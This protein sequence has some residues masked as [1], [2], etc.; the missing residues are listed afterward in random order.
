[1]EQVFVDLR[2]NPIPAH[3]A[4]ADPLYP[5]AVPE[6]LQGIHSI[7]DYLST[8][9][10]AN[11]HLIILGAPGSGKTT[12]LKHVALTLA[13]PRKYLRR[14]QMHHTF[15]ILLFLRDHAQAVTERPDFSLAQ[16]V[17]EHMQRTWQQNVPAT[18]I[19]QLLEKGRCLILL[20][21]L[22]EVADV[23]IRKQ[24]VAWVQR[25]LIAYGH[26][27]F[28]VTSRPYGYRDNPLDGVTVLD[29][30]AF[31]PNQIERFIQNWY[32]ANELKSWNKND[33]SVRLRAREGASDLLDRLH[34]AP[35][36]LALAVNPLLLTMIAT[37][38]RFRSSLP[39]KRVELYREICEVFLGKR[40]EARG[41]AQ[42]LSPAQKQQVLQP[43][44]YSLMQQGKREIAFGE[45]QQV[46]ALALSLVSIQMQPADFLRQIEHTSGLLLERNPGSY[47]FAHLTFQEYLAAVHIKQKGLEQMLVDQVTDVWWHETIRLYCSQADATA[48]ILACLA[49]TPPSAPALT[50]AL[51]CDEEK[52]EVQPHA[53]EQLT[54]VLAAGVEDSDPERRQ[55]VA[56]ALLRRRFRRMIHLHNETYIDTSLVTCAEYQLFLDEQRA[57][58]KYYQPDHWTSYTFPTGTGNTP[59]LGVCQSDALAFCDWLTIHDRE[60]WHYRLPHFEEWPLE[61]RRR[62]K[63]LRAET[64]YW[65]DDEPFFVWSQGK[66]S[67]ILHQQLSRYVDLA[68]DR[69]LARRL[70]DNRVIAHGLAIDRAY[71]RNLAIDQAYVRRLD[72]SGDSVFYLYITLFLLLE[73]IAGNLPAYEGLLLVK[74]R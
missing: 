48:L 57:Q 64:G 35:A 73:R 10:L 7:W 34:Q 69:G 20:D 5:S 55:V 23:V 70:A 52:L 38:H 74:E 22:D 13:Q 2:V 11:S 71:A 66:P 33:P 47:G 39:G 62:Q 21:G 68:R 8:P 17:Q 54:R 60:G 59:I 49:Q 41:I 32:L 51:E 3:Q 1:L 24:V 37:V 43:L 14:Q 56:E 65:V 6:D 4:S 40:H 72:P 19:N 44:A 67:D 50:L 46:I 31:T 26:N 61:E 25:H 12:L 18:W 29:I 36:L 63:E 42:D 16:A 28:V 58:G 15:P 27:R 45:A 9:A 30:L 53:Q